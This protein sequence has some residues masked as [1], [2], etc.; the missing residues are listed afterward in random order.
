[1]VIMEGGN[2]MAFFYDMHM[3]VMLGGRERTQ[4][5]MQLLFGKAGL[6]INRFIPTQSP[7]FIVEAERA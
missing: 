3:L 7:Q 2:P 5:E 1:M 4:E 6:K